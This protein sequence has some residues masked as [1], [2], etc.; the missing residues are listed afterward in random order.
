MPPSITLR[1]VAHVLLLAA[2]LVTYGISL[3]YGETGK[4]VLSDIAG[5]LLRKARASSL[6][7][8]ARR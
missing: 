5:V 1:D 3:V 7:E 4:I 2:A 6:A 8:A